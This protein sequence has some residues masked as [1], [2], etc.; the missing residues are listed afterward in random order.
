M[1]SKT[2]SWSAI[3]GPETTRCP[4]HI[5]PS[6][7]VLDISRHRAPAHWPT[8]LFRALLTQWSVELPV[9][10]TNPRSSHWFLTTLDGLKEDLRHWIWHWR[11]DFYM[12]FWSVEIENHR[13]TM[14]KPISSSQVQV[15]PPMSQKGAT[16]FTQCDTKCWAPDPVLASTKQ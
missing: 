16:P 10:G 11:L 2:A 1:Q 6:S 7:E 5:F 13:N 15:Q 12:D 9:A 4:F 8:G 3:L 14:G